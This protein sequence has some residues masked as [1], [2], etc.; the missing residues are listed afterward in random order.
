MAKSLAE[1]DTSELLATIDAP[2]LF[3]WGNGDR[4]SP[5]SIAE[6]FRTPFPRLS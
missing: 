4:R 2:T 5:L 1:S 6:Q 3:L